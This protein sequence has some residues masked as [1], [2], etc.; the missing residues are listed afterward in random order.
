MFHKLLY[1]SLWHC[2]RDAYYVIIITVIT[3]CLR[4]LCTYTCHNLWHYLQ[5]CKVVIRRTALCAI[6]VHC[7][8]STACYRLQLCGMGNKK[9]YQKY[10]KKV[11]GFAVSWH[12]VVCTFQYIETRVNNY[13]QIYEC[14]STACSFLSSN[15]LVYDALISKWTSVLGFGTLIESLQITCWSQIR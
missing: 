2:H 3:C 13:L 14:K 9:F 12:S 6:Y 7:M 11:S 1:H 15:M 8:Q 4:N 5:A 10:H